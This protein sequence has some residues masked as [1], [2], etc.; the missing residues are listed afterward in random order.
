MVKIQTDTIQLVIMLAACAALF[1][2]FWNYC[3]GHFAKVDDLKN[4]I[5]E[6]RELK[7]EVDQIYFRIIPASEQ[8]HIQ[9]RSKRGDR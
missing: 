8:I 5:E 3:E 2:G 4:E 9:Y 6:R 1:G 7:A